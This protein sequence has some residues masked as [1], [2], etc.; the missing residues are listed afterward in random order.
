MSMVICRGCG[1]VVRRDTHRCE[2]RVLA[3]LDEPVS[4]ETAGVILAR[5]RAKTRD[6]VRRLRER[7]RAVSGAV[8]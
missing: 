8:A 3:R 7:R 6:R 1:D 5:V 4:D 2:G